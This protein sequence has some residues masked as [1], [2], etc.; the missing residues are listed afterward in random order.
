MATHLSWPQGSRERKL[1][2]SWTYAALT[3]V[4]MLILGRIRICNFVSISL[5]RSGRS[6]ATVEFPLGAALLAPL[7]AHAQEE[8]QASQT[9]GLIGVVVIFALLFAALSWVFNLQPAVDESGQVKA[10]SLSSMSGEGQQKKFEADAEQADAYMRK[11]AVPSRPASVWE[12][13]IPNDDGLGY[14]P[15]DGIETTFR[16]VKEAPSGATALEPGDEVTVHATGALCKTMKPFW[17]TK[18]PGQEM[19]TYVAES[20]LLI[21]GWDRGARGMKEGEIRRLRIPAKEGYGDVGFEDWGI[22]PGGDLIFEL[23]VIRIRKGEK[24]S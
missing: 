5:A 13:T 23:E 9:E 11:G 2:S 21:K 4:L 12:D 18:D 8:A 6:A 10:A 7:Q 3:G 24:Q 15:V 17:S 16:V 20:G 14:L 22:P 19:L 1:R